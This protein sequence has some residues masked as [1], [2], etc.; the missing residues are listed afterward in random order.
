MND[1]DADRLRRC[2]ERF[3]AANAEDPNREPDGEP[4]ELVYGRRMSAALERLDPTASVEVRLAVR[5]QH[6][7]R[8][9][10]PRASYPEGREAYLRWRKD[11]G[12]FHADTAGSI[13]RECGYPPETV[14]RVQSIIR[15]ERFK[16]DPWAQQLEDV[17]C[18]VFLEH[19]FEAFVDEQSE[20]SLV[21]I[22]RRTWRKMSD[23][24]RR[25]AQSIDYSPRCAQLL[26]AALESPSDGVS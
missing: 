6:I 22:L 21:N 14:A 7:R 11:L 24:G 15:K 17:A 1:R 20:D 26:A 13:M 9:E 5:A 19:Y 2:L 8:W 23:A 12:R 16:A 18:L 10:I 25:Q 4:K 3:D